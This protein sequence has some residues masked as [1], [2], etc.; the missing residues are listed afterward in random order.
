M[1]KQDKIIERHSIDQGDVEAIIGQ[2]GHT[3]LISKKG[4]SL[5]KLCMISGLGAGRYVPQDSTEVGLNFDIENDKTIIQ[6]DMSGIDP[7]NTAID[8]LSFYR[9]LLLLERTKK[10]TKYQFTY[11]EVA[12]KSG[13]DAGDGFSV[14]VIDR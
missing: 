2:S 4:R 14:A 13:D 5:N 8:T 12:R 7:N 6:C 3:Y 11:M 1:N 10:V 9:Y